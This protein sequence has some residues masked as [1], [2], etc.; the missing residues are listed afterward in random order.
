MRGGRVT[1]A[2]STRSKF[3]PKTLETD[4]KSQS[5]LLTLDLTLWKVLLCLKEEVGVRVARNAGLCCEGVAVNIVSYHQDMLYK[6]VR[7][8]AVV[9]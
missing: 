3:I 5:C 4:S 9:T 8:E 1:A 7:G 6:N 2:V